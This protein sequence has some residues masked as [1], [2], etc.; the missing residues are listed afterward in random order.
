MAKLSLKKFAVWT[1]VAA[2]GGYLAGILTAPKTGRETRQNIEDT[3]DKSLSEGE[4]QLKRALTELSELLD[5][6]KARGTAM[7]SK[8]QMELDELTTR[9]KMTQE[10]A[11]AVLSAL[12]EGESPNKDLHAAVR[13]ANLALNHLRTYLKR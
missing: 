10:K 6:T 1:S 3:A 12:R 2:V 8:A 5:D 7:G 13:D 4:A 9:A 11:R